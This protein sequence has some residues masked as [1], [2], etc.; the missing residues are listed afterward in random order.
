MTHTLLLLRTARASWLKERRV[1]N[2]SKAITDGIIT[3]DSNLF[4]GNYKNNLQRNPK[5]L[6][7][8]HRINTEIQK[9]KTHL[10]LICSTSG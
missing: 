7:P 6:S 10:I 5:L 4:I 9:D 1:K 8:G 3:G 2:P